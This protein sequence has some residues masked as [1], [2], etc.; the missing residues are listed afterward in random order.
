MEELK[1][2]K[3]RVVFDVKVSFVIA[4]L[5]LFADESKMLHWVLDAFLKKIRPKLFMGLFGLDPN[6]GLL[7]RLFLFRVCLHFAL[8]C[9]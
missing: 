2:W 6:N 4:L 7:A 5:E 8:L 1:V 9:L 3:I